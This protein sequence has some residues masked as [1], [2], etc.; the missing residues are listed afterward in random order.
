MT[1]ETCWLCQAKPG[2]KFPPRETSIP[3]C[4]HHWG[5]WLAN[6]PLGPDGGPAPC[7]AHL[8]EESLS[9]R[10]DRLMLTLTANTAD[11]TAKITDDELAA[12]RASDD[13][14]WYAAE[15]LLGNLG[16]AWFPDEGQWL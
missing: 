11:E 6:W 10:G 2:D 8:I 4:W 12:Y 5:P 1:A 9:E 7:G 3:L 15:E 13:H 16:Y 14:K